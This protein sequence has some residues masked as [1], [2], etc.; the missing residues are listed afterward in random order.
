MTPTLRVL[1]LGAAAT[2]IAATTPSPACAQSATTAPSPAAAADYHVTK[3]I[4]LGS[5][6][7]WDYVV[8]DSTS[9]RVFVA[10]GDQVDVVDGT[11][12]DITGHIKGLTGGTHG[13]AVVKDS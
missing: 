3:T 1:I 9:G 4:P 13:I 12:G 2:T 10:H 7:R 11:S 6:D 8:F 5:P